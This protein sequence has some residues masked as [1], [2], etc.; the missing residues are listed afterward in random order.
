MNEQDQKWHES[1]KPSFTTDGQI[2][3]RTSKPGKDAAWK[4][5]PVGGDGRSVVVAAQ[6]V[7]GMVS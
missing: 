3:Y 4:E 6:H 1:F 7:G 5:V 2:I